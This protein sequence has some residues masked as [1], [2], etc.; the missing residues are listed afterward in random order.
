MLANPFTAPSSNDVSPDV[1]PSGPK[2]EE[3]TLWET[4]PLAENVKVSLAEI[5]TPTTCTGDSAGAVSP[6]YPTLVLTPATDPSGIPA[7]HKLDVPGIV[8]EP[9]TL[10]G[11]KL[12]A[13]TKANTLK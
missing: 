5:A 9:D 1:F 10:H 4:N 12:F 2:A 13:R 7:S 3:L 8:I 6:E 11:K